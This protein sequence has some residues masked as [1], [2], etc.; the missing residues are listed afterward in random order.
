M[1]ENIRASSQPDLGLEY[2]RKFTIPLPPLAEQ[3]R[4]VAEVE[5]RL[6]VAQELEQVVSASLKR[7]TRLRQ[8]I[9]K[10]AF[11]GKLVGQNP[12]G[13][14]VQ[15]PLEKI[16]TATDTPDQSILKQERLF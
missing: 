2:I 1:K 12:A 3:Q 15:A 7:S 10:R 9:L 16:N 5:W 8:S 11:E 6:S 4:I 14:L 13:E